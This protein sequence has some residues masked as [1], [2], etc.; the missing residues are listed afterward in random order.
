[1]SD[2]PSEKEELIKQMLADVRSTDDRREAKRAR[3][4]ALLVGDLKASLGQ[5]GEELVQ[6]RGQM[7]KSSDAASRHQQ[8]LVRWTV[9]LSVATIA[10]AVAALLPFFWHPFAAERVW[11]LWTTATV[12]KPDGTSSATQIS[13]TK[14]YATQAEC[15]AAKK[16]IDSR[17]PSVTRG[18]LFVTMTTLTCLPDTADP[19]GPKG[20]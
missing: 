7:A 20:K 4:D 18:D 2:L 14:A 1:M 5:L 10:Y 16:G 11:V 15:E 6:T 9:V 8:A 19:R 12:S 3:L 13:P 17:G